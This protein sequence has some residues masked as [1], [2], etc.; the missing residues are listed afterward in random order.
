MVCIMPISR[1]FIGFLI[2]ASTIAV[3]CSVDASESPVGQSTADSRL[4][5]GITLPTVQPI[6]SADSTPGTTVTSLVTQIQPEPVTFSHDPGEHD[7]PLTIELFSN[8]A[9]SIRYTTD[10]SDPVSGSALTYSGPFTLFDAATVRA[11]ALNSGGLASSESSA[12]YVLIKHQLD[13]PQISN[14]GGA[15]GEPQTVAIATNEPGATVRYT[16]D[17]TLPTEGNGATYTAPLTI[18]ESATLR[19]V[20]TRAGMLDSDPG[21]AQFHIFGRLVERIGD[22]VLAGD[23]EMVIEDTMF[24]HTGNITLSGNARLVIRNSFI[25]HVKDFAF[26][27]GVTATGNSKIVIEDSSIGTNCSGSFNWS[28]FDTASLIADGMEPIRGS[29][30]TWNFMSGTSSIQ[31]VNWDTFSGTVCDGSNVSVTDSDTLEIEFCFPQNSTIDTSLPTAIDTFSFGPDPDNGIAFALSLRDVTVDGWGINVLPGANITIRDSDAI[32]IGV[33]AGLPWQDQTIEMDE[34][35]LKR[36]TERSWQ[37]GT[38]ASLT[39]INTNVYGWEPNAFS[40][41]TMVIRNSD[42]SAS[43][44]NSGDAHYEISGSTVNLI[45]ANERVTMTITNTVITGDVIAND[46]TVIILID[47]EV[48]GTDYGDDGRSG[49]NVF[50]RGNG[51]VILRNTT[52]LGETVTQDSGAIIVE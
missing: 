17:G 34:L 46:D 52:V 48:R 31:V 24:L 16:L 11:I 23:Q 42:F 9:S 6:T 7:G 3:G 45:S 33:I 22:I 13:R 20:N 1:A 50:A 49:G 19:V 28:L 14:R 32:T 25:Q 29:C 18:S 21:E 10:G 41:N 2:I 5:T 47:S 27:Y 43:A 4:T 15:F 40:N 44:V 26:Q 37:I 51:K 30:N 35:A 38:D 8:D 36:Y 39:L 12:D